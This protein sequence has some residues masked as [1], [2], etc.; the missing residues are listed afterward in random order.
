MMEPSRNL[1]AER[2]AKRSRA[3]AL[4]AAVM[5]ILWDRDDWVSGSDV[6]TVLQ[7][8]HPVAYTTALTVLVRMCDKGTVERRR[9]SG[10]AYLFRATESREASAA[11]RI[12][13]V[14]DDAGDRSAVLTHLIDQLDDVRRA[15]LRALLDTSVDED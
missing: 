6:H 4:E 12:Q 15:Q 11:A 13:T 1:G 2:V 5:E 14:L 3:G 7:Q 10:R 9:F 8:A